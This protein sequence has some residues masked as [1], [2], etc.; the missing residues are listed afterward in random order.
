MPY[1]VGYQPFWNPEGTISGRAKILHQ[2]DQFVERLNLIL[3]EITPN[4]KI[5]DIGCAQGWN[6]FELNR[7]KDCN[8]VGV[9]EDE[10]CI[11]IGNNIIEKYKLDS[12]TIS[13]KTSDVRSFFRDNQDTYY[14]YCVCFMLLHHFLENKIK[15]RTLGDSFIMKKKGKELLKQIQSQ[16]K[17]MFLQVRL[18]ETRQVNQLPADHKDVQLIDYLI[19]EIGFKSYKI[20]RSNTNNYFRAPNLIY[21]FK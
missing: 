3:P 19:D 7:I 6:S 2:F 10:E 4:K 21:M 5:I 12:N 15:V 13:F 17:S 18:H 14:D 16:C 8:V 20:L 1:P 9:D 11:D